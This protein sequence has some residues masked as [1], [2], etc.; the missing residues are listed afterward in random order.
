M[1]RQSFTL[2]QTAI[3]GDV[4]LEILRNHLVTTTSDFSYYGKNRETVKFRN[5]A[6]TPKIEQKYKSVLS[7]K[8]S[9]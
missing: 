8:L 5:L 1:G 4:L 6:C 3:G 9:V 2:E 7:C